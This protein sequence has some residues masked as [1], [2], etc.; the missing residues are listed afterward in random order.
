MADTTTTTFGLTKPEVGAS[1]DTW[2]TKLNTNLD[3]I[4]DLLDGTTAIQPNLTEGSWKIGGTAIVATAAEVNRL[5][6]VTSNVQTQ[7]NNLSNDIVSFPTSEDIV[8]NGVTVGQGG[9]SSNVIVQS[10]STVAHGGLL[11]T[12]IGYNTGDA[13]TSSAYWNT[14]V[15]ANA[16]GAE[17]TSWSNTAIGESALKGDVASGGGSN[18][19]V[20]AK[21]GKNGS[22][23]DDNTAVGAEAMQ[24]DG[25]TGVTGDGNTAVGSLALGGISSGANNVAIGEFAGY[26]SQSP[27]SVTTESNR[28]IIGNTSTTNAYIQVSW[29]V[30]SDERDKTDV[31]PVNHGLDFISQL[32]PVQFKWDKRHKYYEYDDDGNVTAKPTPDGT[33]KEDQPFVGFL[34]QEVQQVVNGTGF[35]DNVIVDHE[36]DD[37]WKIKETALIPLLVNAIKELKQRVEVLEAGA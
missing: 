30:T 4:D 33:H 14:A 31:T 35:A 16:L 24:G 20:G 18:V 9:N 37:L 7:L 11:G 3:T 15:G 2:G 10:G 5:D 36:Q 8:V 13:L 21:A 19:F 6:G 12:I 28:V 22:S 34:A 17:T 26:T 1:A 32:N 29:T 25:T 27:F 23:G